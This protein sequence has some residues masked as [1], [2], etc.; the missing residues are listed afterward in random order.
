MTKKLLHFSVILSVVLFTGAGCLNVGGAQPTTSGPSGMY[1]TANKGETWSAISAMPT[2]QG[3]QN[4]DSYSVFGLVE[5]TQDSQGLYWL[6]RESGLFYSFDSG[7]SWKQSGVPFN[8]SLVRSLTVHP[9][10]SCTIYATNGRQV[11]KTVDCVRSWTEVFSEIRT[12]DSITAVAFDPFHPENIYVGE[13]NGDLLKSTDAGRTWAVVYNFGGTSYIRDLS[14]DTNKDG[15]VFVSTL[16]NGLF[17]SKDSGATW[18]DLSLKLAEYPGSTDFR[19]FYIYPSKAEEIYWISKYGVLTSRNAGEDWEPL[20]LVT[21]PGSVDIY[22]F[23]VSRSNSKE[24]YYT[25]T[26]DYRSSFYRSMDG[27]KTWETRK[28]PSGQLPTVLYSHPNN[29]GW[30]YLGYT[31]PVEE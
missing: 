31:I 11:F 13:S 21:P 28:L 1:L 19:R 26:I 17:R 24:I 25:G 15:L 16:Q 4:L 6:S 22:G 9:K 8:A 2:N 7:A 18:T 23:T 20:K 27:G 29:D 5:D 3:V 10:D 14:F 30:I 12:T